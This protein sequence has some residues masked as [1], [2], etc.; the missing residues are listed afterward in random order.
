[1]GTRLRELSPHSKRKPGGR[2]TQRSLGPTLCTNPEHGH[3]K[4][5][6][7]QISLV[8]ALFKKCWHFQAP[9]VLKCMKFTCR[10]AG[11]DRGV[12][13]EPRKFRVAILVCRRHAISRNLAFSLSL[14]CIS[15]YQEGQK[16]WA[17]KLP[18]WSLLLCLCRGQDS[19]R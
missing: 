12:Y 13:A 17:Q 8:T 16:A 6:T 11:K 2:I 5:I 4:A 9:Q 7:M 10:Y 14:S 15:V 18:L 3:K 1:M 19:N